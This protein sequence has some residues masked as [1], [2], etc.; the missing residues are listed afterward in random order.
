MSDLL[1]QS[2]KEKLSRHIESLFA[3]SVFLPYTHRHKGVL[4]MAVSLNL[5]DH[6]LKNL[7]TISEV[8]KDLKLAR[9]WGPVVLA[10][11][12]RTRF[13]PQVSQS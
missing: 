1:C 11:D 2:I 7:L 4:L 6:I 3:A 13:C 9:S 10:R 8:G 5:L 12:Q